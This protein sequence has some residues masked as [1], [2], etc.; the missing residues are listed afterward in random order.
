LLNPDQYV[1]ADRQKAGEYAY[2]ME[3]FK[4]LTGGG[5]L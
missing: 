3:Y 4:A 5:V 2:C 1:K